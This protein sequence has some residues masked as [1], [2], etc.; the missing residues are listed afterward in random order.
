MDTKK[1]I[2]TP[3]TLTVVKIYASDVISTSDAYIEDD[4][5]AWV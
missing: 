1:S 4:E 3:P 5:S 2:Y